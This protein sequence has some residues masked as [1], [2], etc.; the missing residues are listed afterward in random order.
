[1]TSHADFFRKYIDILAEAEMGGAFK[2]GDKIGYTF[3]QAHPPEVHTGTVVK[4]GPNN[5]AQ[6][7]WDD[8]AGPSHNAYASADVHNGFYNMHWAKKADAPA[9]MGG[10]GEMDEAVMDG[11][12]DGEHPVFAS[13]ALEA[14]DKVSI[15]NVAAGNLKVF[16]AT[17]VKVLPNN[18]VQLSFKDQMGNYNGPTQSEYAQMGGEG[19][20]VFDTHW[21]KKLK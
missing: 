12:E 8:G 1:M 5:R 20:G 17:V 16:N 6:I 7:Q 11:H 19:N 10:A 15:T 4:L 13:G 18:K 14:G 2:V 9:S 3:V 21:V